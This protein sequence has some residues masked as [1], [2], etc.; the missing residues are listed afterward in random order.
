MLG[1]AFSLVS[2]LGTTGNGWTD[3]DFSGDGVVNVLSDAFTLIAN[4]GR[5]VLPPASATSQLAF[6]AGS[7]PNPVLVQP[8]LQQSDSSKA[9]ES[10]DVPL[11]D[12]N[13]SVLAGSQELDDAFASEDWLI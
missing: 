4:L 10:P 3:G 9:K 11:A 13:A 1:D 2:N 5:S 7:S 6:F 12:S 8:A